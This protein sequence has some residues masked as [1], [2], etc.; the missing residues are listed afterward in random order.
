MD[1]QSAKISV[2]ACHTFLVVEVAVLVPKTR[3][4]FRLE[5]T[6]AKRKNALIEAKV[7]KSRRSK[8]TSW[9]Q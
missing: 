7:E 8:T 4:K 6:E 9:P 2:L 1:L 5:E 3:E